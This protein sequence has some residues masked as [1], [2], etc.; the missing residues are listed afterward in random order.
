M[1]PLERPVVPVPRVHDVD[2]MAPVADDVDDIFEHVPADIGTAEPSQDEET[3]AAV[4]VN[5]I[6]VHAGAN[7]H[8]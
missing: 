1:D 6:G 5:G 4:T 8:S 7:C 3:V 2:R